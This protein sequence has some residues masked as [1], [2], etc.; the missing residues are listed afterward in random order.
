MTKEKL[1]PAK[2]WR[3]RPIE[4]WNVTTF[5]EYLK[6]KHKELFGCDYVPFGGWGA[7]QRTLGT[8]IGTKSR[9]NPKPRTASNESV[10]EFIDRTFESYRPNKKYPGTSFGFM[11]TYRKFE[12]QKIQSEELNAIRRKERQEGTSVEASA[13][14]EIEDITEWW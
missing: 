12:W 10:K 1:A 13:P 11:W 2:D 5:T 9:T 14:T 3:N 4:K 6:S 7:E 8:L